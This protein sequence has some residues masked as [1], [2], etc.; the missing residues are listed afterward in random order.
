MQQITLNFAQPFDLAKYAMFLKCKQLPESKLNYDWETDSYNI[1]TH[2][3][4]AHLLGMK[5][6]GR[7]AAQ[8]PLS[9][10]LFDY[11]RFIVARALEAKRYAIYADCGLGKTVMFLEYARHIL[12]KTGG[13][14]LIFSPL[15]IIL[16]T[17]EESRRFYGGKLSVHQLK[18]RAELV[19]WLND[20][21]S[22]HHLAITNYEKMI[23]GELPE[24]NRLAGM[25]ADESSIFKTGGGVIK[26]NMLHS[27]NGKSG[28]A[29]LGVEYRLSCTAT[30][31]PNDI[32]EYASQASFLGKLRT[33]GEIL[34]TYFSR[35]KFGNWQIKPYAK[36]G[37]Y[38]FLA[39]WSIYIRNPAHYGFTDNFRDIPAPQFHT[40][41]IAQSP[42]QQR[43]E[44]TIRRHG[45]EGSLFGDT[46][47]GVV[48]RSKLSQ[49]AK[50]FVYL[51]D[52]S[53][54]RVDSRKPAAVAE[55]IKAAVKSGSQVLVWT[56]FDEEGE[57][58][59]EHLRKGQ[60]VNLTG[61]MSEAERALVIEDFR[62][63]TLPV[64]ISKAGLLGFGLNFQ[65]CD[66]MIFSGWNDSYEQFYQA[67][68]RA[69]RYGQKKTL[70]VH[71]PVIPQLEEAILENVLH[72]KGNFERDAQEH[73]DVYKKILKDYGA[74]K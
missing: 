39:S 28:M 55:L 8:Q 60:A 23:D 53:V 62:H 47:L 10:F 33:D 15:Q 52:H 29:P 40:H 12:H 2:P 27:L 11:Q 7:A 35:D 18:T 66:T 13:K 70:Q 42:E 74:I 17:I 57:I 38:R 31:A 58:I 21:A 46:E 69:H 41:E 54:Q 30:P 22:P 48:K 36:E 50:G 20:D 5:A 73:E 71:L 59:L 32:M 65:F 26:W 1:Q 45:S 51:K 63:G 44:L 67:I 19:A 72:K 24:L 4:F 61:K 43:M 25:I 49:I 68:K 14:V 16:Q 6:E 3:R 56:V 9:D 37:F 64:L 34:W